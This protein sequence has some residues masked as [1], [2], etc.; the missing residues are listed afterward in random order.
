[1]KI[2][3]V[4]RDHEQ[5]GSLKC[6]RCGKALC[7]ACASESKYTPLLCPKCEDKKD[8]QVNFHTVALCMDAIGKTLEKMMGDM[9]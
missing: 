9:E 1:M 3:D 8:L 6:A 5:F 4:C 2:C 7:G